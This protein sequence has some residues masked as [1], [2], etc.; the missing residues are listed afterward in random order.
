MVNK[1]YVRQLRFKNIVKICVKYYSRYIYVILLD[2][3]EKAL[4]HKYMLTGK[5]IIEKGLLMERI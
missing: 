3:K 2:K 5:Y 4:Y 1:T